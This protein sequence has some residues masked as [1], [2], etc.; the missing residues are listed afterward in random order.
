MTQRRIAAVY[1]VILLLVAGLNSIPGTR[2]AQG[3]VFGTF[4][5]DPFDDALHLVSALWAAFAAWKGGVAA[6]FFLIVFGAACLLDGLMGI[7]T[8]YGF[9]DF[10]NFTN[11]LMP[12]SLGLP[13][14]LANL[15]HIGL[16]AIA[17]LRRVVLWA[18]IA[19]L[20]GNDRIM[21]TA[22]S[23]AEPEGALSAAQRQGRTD[24]RGLYLL[25]VADLAQ[26]L[27]DL[28]DEGI[29]LAHIH[30]Y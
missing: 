4:A 29:T 15:P 10:A 27:R 22:L 28:P 12:F 19:L 11:D 17:M 23:P 13:R 8:G 7:A 25:H 26:R 14:L 21:F 2:D 20:A 1:A 24:W 5:L 18:L 6:R 30:D 16:G 9:L 3:L